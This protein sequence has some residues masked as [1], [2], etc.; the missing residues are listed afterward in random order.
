MKI[1]TLNDEKKKTYEHFLKQPMQ[2][3]EIRFNVLIA[4]IHIL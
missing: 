3:E 4:K 2:A 1:T